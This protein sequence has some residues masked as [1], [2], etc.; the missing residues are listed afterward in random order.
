MLAYEYLRVVWYVRLDLLVG[1]VFLASNLERGC[2][3][4]AY[5]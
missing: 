2:Q 5:M 4:I 1:R 3:L